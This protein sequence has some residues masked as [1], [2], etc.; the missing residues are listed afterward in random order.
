MISIVSFV[1]TV[2]WVECW[3]VD[4][5]LDWRPCPAPLRAICESAFSKI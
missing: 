1:A 2:R 5:G 4:R 3:R